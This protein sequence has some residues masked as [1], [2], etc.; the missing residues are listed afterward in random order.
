MKVGLDENRVERKK[1][2]TE[3]VSPRRRQT[4]PWFGFLD[5]TD[6]FDLNKIDK[7]RFGKFD[8]TYE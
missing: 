4:D 1:G 3:L 7:K 2:C 8:L 6:D 5:V